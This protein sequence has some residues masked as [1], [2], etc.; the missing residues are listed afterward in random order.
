MIIIIGAGIG[1]LSLATRL[2]KSGFLVKII[3]KN[4][5]PGGRCNYLE[6]DGHLLDS[7][8]TVFMMKEVYTKTFADIGEKMDDYIDL[9][10]V[11]P[12]H[13]IYFRDGSK[14]IMTTDQKKMKDQ[15]EAFEQ[16]SYNSLQR[17][18][19]E[20]ELDYFLCLEAS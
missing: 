17:Y 6:K 2:A 1:G 16:G 3:E 15:M 4:A 18:L 7:G 20:G 12:S 10:R 13:Q 19:K 11:D 5:K 9:I 8:P 14:F